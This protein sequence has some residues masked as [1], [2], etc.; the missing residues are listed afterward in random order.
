MCS[1]LASITAGDEFLESKDSREFGGEDR[2]RRVFSESDDEV[3]DDM[4]SPKKKM[5]KIPGAKIVLLEGLHPADCAQSAKEFMKKRK[6]GVQ[7]SSMV[8]KNANQAL[9][10][11]SNSGILSKH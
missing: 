11:L 8:L 2:T 9:R 1:N 7:R 4:P 10:L 3:I 5:P 6:H